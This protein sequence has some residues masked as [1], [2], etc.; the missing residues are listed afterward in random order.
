MENEM[1]TTNT[2]SAVTTMEAVLHHW[3]GHR[4]LTRRVIEAFP[5]NE[6]FTFSIG[7]MRPF[8]TIILELIDISDRGIEGIATDQ[9]KT[10]DNHDDASLVPPTKEEVLKRWDEITE[11]INSYWALIAPQRFAEDVLAFGMYEGKA[12]KILQYFIDNEIH[13]RGQGYVYLRALGV[14]PPPFWDRP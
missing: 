7:G 3:Q 14:Q 12:F 4:S 8:S 10:L 6:L 5:E 2:T 11:K 13:H 9:W 1:V